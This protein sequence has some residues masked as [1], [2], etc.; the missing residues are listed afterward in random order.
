MLF[1]APGFIVLY[2]V[3]NSSLSILYD[4]SI[5]TLHTHIGKWRFREDK[6]L[7]K[8]TEGYNWDSKLGPPN[9]AT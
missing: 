3:F 2:P 6:W 9:I 5:T 4:E 1:T 7:P 8:V